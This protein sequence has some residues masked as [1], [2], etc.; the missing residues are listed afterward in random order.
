MSLCDFISYSSI[1]F[2]LLKKFFPSAVVKYESVD[3]ILKLNDA[4]HNNLDFL[5]DSL[6][7]SHHTSYLKIG[8]QW[9]TM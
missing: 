3:T 5:L 2:Y 7:I 4:E 1:N 6:E 8:T 9:Y